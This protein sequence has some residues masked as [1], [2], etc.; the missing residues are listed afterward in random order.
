MARQLDSCVA[1]GQAMGRLDL[2]ARQLAS[3]LPSASHT[4]QAVYRAAKAKKVAKPGSEQG[5]QPDRHAASQARLAI[6][7]VSN[8]MDLYPTALLA[9]YASS[10]PIPLYIVVNP[11]GPIPS[12]PLLS[13]FP[14]SSRQSGHQQPGSQ[15]GCGPVSLQAPAPVRTMPCLAGQQSSELSRTKI[16]RHLRGPA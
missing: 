2:A 11:S 6:I 10:S 8:T 15:S 1:P 3:R 14:P 4:G 5:G 7:A 9:C 16:A 12:S 13:A